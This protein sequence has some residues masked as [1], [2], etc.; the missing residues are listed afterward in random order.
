VIAAEILGLIPGCA[1]GHPPLAVLPLQGGRGCNVVLRVDTSAGRFVLRQRQPPL[2]RP[3]AAAQMELRSQ[4]VA[5]AA[6]LAPRVLRAAL[7]GSWLLMEYIDAPLWTQEQLLTRESVERLGARLGELHRLPMQP[8][9]AEMDAVAIAAGFLD[10]IREENSATAADHLPLLAR[11]R[12]LSQ[13]IEGRAGPPALNHGDLQVA[14]LLGEQP[15][16]IDWE[17]AQIADPTYDIACLLGYYPRLEAFRDR[18]MASAGL[19]KS[20]EMA[21]LALQRERFSCLERLWNLASLAK[22]G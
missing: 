17:Y 3:G 13:G 18:L 1:D 22:A 19:I 4:Q 7:D 14:N 10:Q 16:L 8:G 2:D 11:V 6:G 20:A 9:L 12:E 15:L 21:I 5:A